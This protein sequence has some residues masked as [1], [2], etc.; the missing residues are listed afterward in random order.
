MEN[1]IKKSLKEHP[2]VG[3]VGSINLWNGMQ[4]FS[5]CVCVNICC[6]RVYDPKQVRNVR[7]KIVAVFVNIKYQFLALIP[8]MG[9]QD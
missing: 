8:V 5:V 2:W 3:F 9:A 1:R 6:Q 4:N 7:G